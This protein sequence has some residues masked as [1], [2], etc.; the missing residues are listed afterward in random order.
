MSIDVQVMV[1]VPTNGISLAQCHTLLEIEKSHEISISELANT[2]SLD[3]STVSRTVDGL[4]NINMRPAYRI[5]STALPSP[6]SCA[7]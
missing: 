1:L 5:W 7:L 4:V 6:R 2:L 3:K